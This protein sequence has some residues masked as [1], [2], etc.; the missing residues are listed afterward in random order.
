MEKSKSIFLQE[1]HLL[2][3]ISGL[4]RYLLEPVA[5]GPGIHHLLP[6]G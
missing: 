3:L 2:V 1:G 6:A 4:I 5:E